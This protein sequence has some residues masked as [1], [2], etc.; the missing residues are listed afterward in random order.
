MKKI[1]ILTILI[2]IKAIFSASD[3]A[4]TYLNKSL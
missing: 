4:F 1:V 2:A 3:T